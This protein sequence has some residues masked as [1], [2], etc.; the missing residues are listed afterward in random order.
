MEYISQIAF[1]LVLAIAGYFLAQRIGSIKKNINLGKEVDR[2]DNKG[3]RWK[4]TLLIAFGQKKMFKKLI[5][6]ILHLMIYVGFL[7]I[8]L[9]VLEFIIDG[10]AGTHRIFA[11]FLGDAYTI[12]INIFEFLAVLVLVSCVAFLLR[13]N[14]LSVPR[15]R[16][17]K[18]WPKLDGNLILVIEI[19]LMFAILT[20][21]ATDQLLQGKDDHYV[22]TG[23]FFFS[24]FLMPIFEGMSVEALVFTERFAWWFHIIGILAFAVYV[25]YSKHLHIFMAFPNTYFARITPQGKMNNMDEV[26]TEVKSMLGMDAGDPPAEVARLGAKD[27]TDLTWVNLMNAYA[28]TECGRCTAECPA[29]ITGKKLSPRKIMMDTRDRI[30]EIGDNIKAGKEAEEGSPLFSDD[31]ISAEELNACTSCNACVEACPIN[32]N[33]L[34]IILQGRRY[35]AMEESSSPQSWNAMFQNVETSFAPWK[36]PP[37]DRFKWADKLKEEEK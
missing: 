35:M 15:L 18:G 25:T 9:E 33:P 32:I 17:L 8:N 1:L 19:I 16:S 36:F 27:A 24:S 13:R 22:Q 31:Y 5:P 23:S 29:N 6:A 30:T 4:N 12:A 28:C 37:T 11:P 3:Q 20:M 21:N 14:V 2:S 7:V 10:V 26:T 34:D